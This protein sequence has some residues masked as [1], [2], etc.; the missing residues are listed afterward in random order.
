MGGVVNKE[1]G[2]ERESEGEWSFV[3][4]Y[5]RTLEDRAL[6]KDWR[7]RCGMFWLLRRAETGSGA[8]ARGGK[9]GG[10]GG[11]VEECGLQIVKELSGLQR[12]TVSFPSSQA[13]CSD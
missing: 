3:G 1:R 5:C 6:G 7:A 13:D 2:R 8:C 12:A 4:N 9:R 11:K 10:A